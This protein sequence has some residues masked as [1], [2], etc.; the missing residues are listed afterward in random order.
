M[1]RDRR[2][3]RRQ[4]LRGRHL[5]AAVVVSAAVLGCTAPVSTPTAPTERSSPATASGPTTEP[6]RGTL[7]IGL[8]AD[9]RSLDPRLIADEEGELIVGAVFE[10]L[11]RVAE[12]HR[13]VRGAATSWAVDA[14]G[15]TFTFALREGAMF[16]DGTPV[17]AADVVR[18]F[19]RIADGTAQPASPLIH[20]VEPIVGADEALAGGSLAG[21]RALDELT[22][23]IELAEPDPRY[24]LTLADPALAPTPPSADEDP[25]AF[26]AQP[27]GNGPFKLA[28]PREPG[29]FIRLTRVAEHHRAP[30]VDEVVFQIYPDDPDHERQWRDLSEGLLQVADVGPGRLEEAR[31]IYGSSADGQQGPGVLD[32]PIATVTT[33]AF[34]LSTPPYDDPS[35]RRAISQSIDREAIAGE[36]LGGTVAPADGL[37]PPTVPGAQPGAC[38]HCRFDPEGAAALLADAEVELPPLTL[39]TNRGTVHT[40]V[41]GRIAA[42]VRA[43]LGVHVR[44]VSRDLPE[45]AQ[46]IVD[47]AASWY[48]LGWDANEPDPGAFLTPL[49]R[50]GSPDNLQGF[51]DPD[52]DELLDAARAEPDSLASRAIYGD[53]ERLL[54]DQAVAVPL[55]VERRMRVVTRDVRGFEMLSSGR[56]DLARVTLLEG[57]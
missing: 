4:G 10:P 17:T 39:V 54:L 55:V 40:A 1:R 8:A 13:L 19:E 47:R 21:V 18:T 46:A 3:A 37:V 51:S 31:S 23:E 41:A 24:L 16:H 52:V 30:R 11:V 2:V 6:T 57:R 26:A 45:L 29:T 36:V 33:L 44:V 22:V 14:E 53:A 20:L 12:R 32:A 28:E 50:T 35:V 25:S 43:A 7:R 34:D 15:R 49:F 42:D 38:D 5:V 27:I 9:P 56:V 48:R